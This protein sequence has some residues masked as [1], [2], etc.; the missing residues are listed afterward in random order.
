M[1]ADLRDVE[2]VFHLKNQP[3]VRK[4][5]YSQKKILWENHVNWFKENYKYFKI[6]C[7]GSYQI[8]YVRVH[9][10]D[11]IGD[12]HIALLKDYQGKGIGTKVIKRMTKKHK[13]LTTQVLLRNKISIKMFEKSG[14]KKMGK[15]KKSNKIAVVM[16]K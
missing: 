11:I 9:K 1:D 6:I 4:A 16:K 14:F 5:S 10:G 8:G 12:I 13:H 3:Y 7:L 2:F 15:I